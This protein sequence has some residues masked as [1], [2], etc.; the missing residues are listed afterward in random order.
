[1]S[2]TT[3]LRRPFVTDTT[4][5]WCRGRGA[6]GGMPAG[7]A[8]AAAAGT[9][10]AAGVLAELMTEPLLSRD[11]PAVQGVERGRD[12]LEAVAGAHHLAGGEG[13]HAVPPVAQVAIALDDLVRAVAD[14]EEPAGL[15]LDPGEHLLGGGVSGDEHG[16]AGGE[17]LHRRHA[18]GLVPAGVDEEVVRPQQSG[19]LVRR[20]RVEDADGVRD[21][22]LVGELR[23]SPASAHRRRA[24]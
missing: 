7:P 1:M 5:T 22:Q 16:R 8:T 23:A 11:V 20:H 18:E 13:I 19:H 12:G 14:V 21:A 6:P 24:A 4:S 10:T 9:R 3:P 17:R 2:S 15:L